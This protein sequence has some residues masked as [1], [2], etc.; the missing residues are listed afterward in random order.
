[1]EREQEKF[2]SFVPSC[3]AVSRARRETKKKNF[4]LINSGKKHEIDIDFQFDLK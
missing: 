2:L 4:T 3:G 1:V